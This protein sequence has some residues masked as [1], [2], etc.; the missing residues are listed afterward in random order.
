MPRFRIIIP[1]EKAED[2]LRSYR[3]IVVRIKKEQITP[4]NEIH[5]KRFE[6]KIELLEDLIER[7]KFIK[8]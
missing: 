3:S 6:A 2:M 7:Y 5:I 8:K 4:R 1:F